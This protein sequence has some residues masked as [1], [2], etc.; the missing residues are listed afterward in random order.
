MSAPEVYLARGFVIVAQ[1]AS[2]SH[3]SAESEKP[4]LERTSL[5][6]VRTIPRR[7]RPPSSIA[8]GTASCVTENGKQSHSPA[9]E[10]RDNMTYRHTCE[11]CETPT[12]CVAQEPRPVNRSE[13]SAIHSNF[14]AVSIAVTMDTRL[15]QLK[16]TGACSNPKQS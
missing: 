16:R 5:G 10:I 14:R 12:R 15:S 8:H 13:I 11:P 7:P 3:T 9:I 6:R 4:T 1:A 2:L